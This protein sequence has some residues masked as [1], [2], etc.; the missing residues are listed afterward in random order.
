MER[1][2]QISI[3]EMGM[4]VRIALSG[5]FVG[6]DETA[7]VREAILEYGTNGQDIVIDLSLVKYVNS[8]FLGTL[9]AGQTAVSRIGGRV[10]VSGLSDS[11]HRLFTTTQLNR[12]ISIHRTVDEAILALA[13][14]GKN[15]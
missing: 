10:V 14:D 12:L 9:L 13:S 3:E 6:G 4:V 2:Q 11:L 7:T 15:S 8:S 1:N 5:Q